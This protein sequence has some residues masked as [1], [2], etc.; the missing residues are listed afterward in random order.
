MTTNSREL[1]CCHHVERSSDAQ[2]QWVAK[3]R[4]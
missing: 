4:W 2:S 3:R 1:E